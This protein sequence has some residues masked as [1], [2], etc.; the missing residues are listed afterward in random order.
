[1]EV[2]KVTRNQIYKFMK[3]LLYFIPIGIITNNRFVYKYGE[4]SFIPN[5][6]SIINNFDLSKS[7]FVVSVFSF[8]SFISL[9]VEKQI[10]PTVI[11][12][13]YKEVN[14]DNALKTVE[15]IFGVNVFEKIKD[16]NPDLN[17]G[18]EILKYFSYFITTVILWLI[19]FNSIISF[20]LIIPFTIISYYFLSMINSLSKQKT[21][22]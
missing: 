9:F 4:Y 20:I 1:M 21:N 19:S 5:I 15:S 6:D 12:L 2:L 18:Y 22:L 11:I 3:L 7:V 14:T 16:N 10:I 17:T 8:F 13:Y